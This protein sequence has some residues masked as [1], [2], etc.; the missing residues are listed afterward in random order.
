M[1]VVTEINNSEWILKEGRP[2]NPNII[3][4]CSL[5]TR[6]ESASP[7]RNITIMKS[8]IIIFQIDIKDHQVT[9]YTVSDLTNTK[10]KRFFNNNQQIHYDTAS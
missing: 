3:Y 5:W 8:K 1:Y 7:Y 6:I 2:A 10:Q 4:F 9:Y